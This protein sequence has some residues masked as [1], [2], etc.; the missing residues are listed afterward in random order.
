MPHARSLMPHAKAAQRGSVLLFAL[1]TLVAL[2]VGTLGLIRSVDTGAMLL[3]NLGFKQDAT[4]SAD[5][6]TRQAIQWLS[7]N[8]TVL[9]TDVAASA[10]YASTQKFASDGTTPRPPV[11]ATGKQLYG[12]VNRQLIDWDNNNCRSTE[13]GTYISCSIRALSAGT[14]NGNQASYVV[15]RLCSKTGDSALDATVNCAKPMTASDS[16]A[17]GRGGLDYSESSRFNS[18]SGP[19]YRVVVR[20]LGARNTASFTETI[21]HF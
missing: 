5:R 3:G 13:N 2:M 4:A 6:V 18:S 10:Y 21:V 20:I 15:F 14:V 11:D 19:Y 7:E 1:I 17:S 9:N 8:R 12:N 16:A